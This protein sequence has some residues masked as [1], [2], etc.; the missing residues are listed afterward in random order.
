MDDEEEYISSNLLV[1]NVTSGF[2]DDLHTPRRSALQEMTDSF[3]TL[4]SF[5]KIIR[6]VGGAD[7]LHGLGKGHVH[8]HRHVAAV[9][10]ARHGGAV[11]L[12]LEPRERL[13]RQ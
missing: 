13:E 5:E 9:R 11:S 10:G 12:E 4:A 1:D 3:D 2:R 7:A 6:R 8:L